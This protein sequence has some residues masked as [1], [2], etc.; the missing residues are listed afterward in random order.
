MT[1]FEYQIMIEDEFHAT[2]IKGWLTGN[3]YYYFKTKQE[4]EN[5]IIIAKLSRC[6]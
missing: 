4:A 6:S 2:A 3:T 1:L 5:F